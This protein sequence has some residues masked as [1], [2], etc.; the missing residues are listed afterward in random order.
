M[1]LRAKPTS[2]VKM[3]SAQNLTNKCK[4][5]LQKFGHSM[6]TILILFQ[7]VHFN[8]CLHEVDYSQSLIFFREFVDVHRWVHREVILVSWLS[9]TAHCA[10]HHP[11]PR[12]LC[13]LS[14]FTCNK[15]SRWQPVKINDRHI[16]SHGK[17][18]VLWTVYSLSDPTF[19]LPNIVKVAMCVLFCSDSTWN[20]CF[21]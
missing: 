18:T 14:S 13:S 6:V 17:N 20:V 8:L 10:F 5:I 7:I 2:V 9:K 1:N 11:Y 12:A 4:N 19:K 16:Q 15:R 21:N 3:Y